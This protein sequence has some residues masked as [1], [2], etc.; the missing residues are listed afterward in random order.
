MLQGIKIIFYQKS[1]S[2]LAYEFFVNVIKVV[3][4][5]SCETSEHNKDYPQIQQLLTEDKRK[6][7]K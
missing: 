5:V 6:A 3:T 1:Y 2:H 4:F 7:F